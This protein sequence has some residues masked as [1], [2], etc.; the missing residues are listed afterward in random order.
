VAFARFT[1]P[2]GAPADAAAARVDDDRGMLSKPI[3]GLAA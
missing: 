3:V 1:Q 2:F